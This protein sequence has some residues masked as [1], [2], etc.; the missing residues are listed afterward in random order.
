MTPRRPAAYHV[1]DM[2]P[3]FEERI[4]ERAS[5]LG[6]RRV[7][8]TP[9]GPAPRAEAFR[10]WLSRGFAGEMTWLESEPA[11]RADVTIR[12][13]WARTIVSAAFHYGSPAGR[14]PFD[15]RLIPVP[16]QRGAGR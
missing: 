14:P 1:R 5:E 10:R 16:A 4:R 7:A 12:S 8:F 3:R 6:F 13:P 15:P 11:S 2:A 9:A